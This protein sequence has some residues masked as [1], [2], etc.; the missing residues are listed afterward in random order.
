MIYL[1][2]VGNLLNMQYEVPYDQTD[3]VAIDIAI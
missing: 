2:I 3:Q 1:Q